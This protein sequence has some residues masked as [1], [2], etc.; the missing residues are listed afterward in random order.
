MQATK[1][2][3]AKRSPEEN[4]ERA[5]AA[6]VQRYQLQRAAVRLLATVPRDNGKPYRV[7]FCRWVFAYGNHRSALMRVEPTPEA[8][9]KSYFLGL[10]TCGSVWH[11][12]CCAFV[13]SQGRRAE[14]NTA[15]AWARAERL[16]PVMLTLTLRHQAGEPLG[17][18]L[19]ALRD[20]KR[21][22]T[23]GRHRLSS[24]SVGSITACEVTYGRNG[25]HPHLHIVL[26][27]K[28][29]GEV[30]AIAKL[31]PY[32]ERWARA[33][34]SL[35]RDGSHPAAFQV[36]G[37]A[38]A[39]EYL[40]KWG[41][42]EE[43]TLSRVKRTRRTKGTAAQEQA[44]SLAEARHQDKDDKGATPL[45]LL[46][47]ASDAANPDRRK[48]EALWL[49]YAVVFQGRHQLDWSKG[50]KKLARVDEVTDEE[51]AKREAAAVAVEIAS[52][53]KKDWRKVRRARAELLTAAEQGR[54]QVIAKVNELRMLGD[55]GEE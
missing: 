50:L 42:A 55:D 27:I 40:T 37:A 18:T 17:A 29:R 4:S 14:V 38:K 2:D 39:G 7:A 9:A 16:K 26:F 1:P 36:Q 45:E 15:L 25:W 24:M 31:E 54:V 49:E 33:L 43:L 8:A 51:L 3:R 13:I 12:P 10:Q 32:R 47:A 21:Q 11:C 44:A 6:R 48:A 35:G 34:E 30:D 19:D 22:L 28:T 53:D 41:A 5:R 23:K 46:I 20:A 52:F